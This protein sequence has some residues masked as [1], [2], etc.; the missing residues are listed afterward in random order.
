MA[1][2]TLPSTQLELPIMVDLK[3]R[4]EQQVAQTGTVGK[5][6][7]ALPATTRRHVDEATA[8][9]LSVYDAISSN[10]VRGTK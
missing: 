7:S 2:T 6:V 4:V 3:R 9:D 1:K 5:A 8:T 10:Y